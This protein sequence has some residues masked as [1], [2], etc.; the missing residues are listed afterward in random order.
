M[1]PLARFSKRART[2]TLVPLKMEAPLTLPAHVHPLTACTLT[3]E[4]D[5]ACGEWDG[6]GY[7]RYTAMAVGDEFVCAIAESGRARC[8]THTPRPLGAGRFGARWL[9]TP[10]PTGPGR[11]YVALDVGGGVGGGNACALTDLGEA[12][13][14]GW[15]NLGQVHVLEGRY[16]AISAGYAST[17]ALT[18]TGAAVCWGARRHALRDGRYRAIA[19]GYRAVCGLTD[20]GEAV[21][22]TPYPVPDG[23]SGPFT[24]ITLAWTGDARALR[25]NGEAVCW[26]P[27]S[28][29]GWLDVPEGRWTAIDAGG[30][31][32]CAIGIAGEVV[33]WGDP[34]LE[35]RAAPPG[36]PLYGARHEWLR[37]LPP[38][39]RRPGLLLERERLAERGAPLPRAERWGPRG[40]GQR[41]P[42][43]RLRTDRDGPGGVLGDAVRGRAVVEQARLP[44]PLDRFAR[45]A[46]ARRGGTV[47]RVCR[48]R[49][50]RQPHPA[51]PGP[52][53]GTPLARMSSAKASG[54]EGLM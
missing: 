50:H 21:C 11:R 24:Q 51:G 8:M 9:M 15:D 36:G 31:H 1:A 14:W 34:S 49:P 3:P 48:I 7:T 19:A 35:I 44:G 16:T 29:R 12:V 41:G 28:E 38:L 33:C 5:P 26:G 25:V 32:A 47:E 23:P 20:D 10:P 30:N 2:G 43:P 37:P 40:G 52:V 17:C 18:E 53:L 45:L 39:R 27:R 42:R 22:S 46:G 6:D 54:S 4:G 13:C